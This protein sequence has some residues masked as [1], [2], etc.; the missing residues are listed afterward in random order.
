M[1]IDVLFPGVIPEEWTVPGL[2]SK[3]GAFGWASKFSRTKRRG[4]LPVHFAHPLFQIV[5]EL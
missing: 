1:E 4:S 2:P 5:R 3:R